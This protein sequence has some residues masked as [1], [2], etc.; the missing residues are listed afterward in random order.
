MPSVIESHPKRADIDAALLSGLSL[1]KVHK[2]FDLPV[3]SQALWRYKRKVLI[4][5]ILTAHKVLKAETAINDSKPSSVELVKVAEQVSAATP[6]IAALAKRDQTRDADMAGAREAGQW[7]AVSAF[8]RN[9]L[10][11]LRTQAE[12]TGA[13]D[14]PTEAARRDGVGLH[15]HLHQHEHTHA[16]P[17]PAPVDLGPIVEVTAVPVDTDDR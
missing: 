4:P 8:D 14:A 16:P 17:E 7:G 10:A 9:G 11:D 6:I 12:L 2:Q 13:L 5:A 3:S 1:A 15:V